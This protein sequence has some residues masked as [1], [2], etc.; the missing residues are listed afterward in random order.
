M[1]RMPRYR[2]G[3]AHLDEQIRALVAQLGDIDDADLIFELMVTVCRLGRERANRGDLKLVNAALREM[4][5]AIEAF[6]PYRAEHKASI[7]GSARTAESDPLYLQTVDVA[8]RLADE[9]WMVITGAGPGIMAA[10]LEGAGADASFGLPIRLPFEAS[11]ADLSADRLINFRYFFTRKLTFIKE[12]DG[13]V[14]LPGG[15]G[16]MDE[17]FELLTLMQTGKAQLSPVVLLDVPG[18]TYWTHWLEFLNAELGERGYINGDDRAFFRLTDDAG[19]A[20]EELR[21]FYRNYHSQ[22]YVDGALVLRLRHE[23][24]AALVARLNDEFA[25]IVVDG[26]IERIDATPAEVADDDHPG[27]ARLRL[28]F[29]RHH[30]ARLRMLIDVVNA[31][32]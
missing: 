29:N 17:A 7:F 31:A 32:V 25:D 23:P 13:F 18:G 27:L 26:R 9:G 1:A 30:Y 14:I 2:T 4:R 12:S 10:G 5:L 20:V 15:F 3:D 22:R 21:T 19:V 24:S 11:P 6:V 16:T 28:R 8:R